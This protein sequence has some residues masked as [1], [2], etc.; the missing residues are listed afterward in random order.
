MTDLSPFFD[1]SR[2]ARGTF[3][4]SLVQFNTAAKQLGRS[5]IT[6]RV[7]ALADKLPRSAW[8]AALTLVALAYL[9]LGVRFAS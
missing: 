4:W 9:A 3:A 6:P 5:M 1:A 2:A 7:Q 8:L